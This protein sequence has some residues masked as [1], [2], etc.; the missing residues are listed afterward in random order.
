VVILI[1]GHVVANTP[2]SL[3]RYLRICTRMCL[4]KTHTKHHLS[5][6]L[7]PLATPFDR[8]FQ[9]MVVSLRSTEPQLFISKL[10]RLPGLSLPGHCLPASPGRAMPPVGCL[11][12]AASRVGNRCK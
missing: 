1:V 4:Y 7:V 12:L 5:H 8:W 10:Q 3:F 9:P 2:V 11:A 6:C